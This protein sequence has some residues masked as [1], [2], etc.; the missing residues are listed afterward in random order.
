[1]PLLPGV[2]TNNIFRPLAAGISS[3]AFFRI[4][5]RLGQLVYSTTT[6]G[7]GWDGRIN[8]RLAEAGA[9]VWFVQGTTYTGHTVFHKGTMLL[10]R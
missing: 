8:G 6:L 2:A 9:F 3:L 7:D 4:Y 5:N 10:V 1:M